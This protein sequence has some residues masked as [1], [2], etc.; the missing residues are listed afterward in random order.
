L[1]LLNGGHGDDLGFVRSMP[2]QA[3]HDS[4]FAR[5]TL[6]A[7]I[8]LRQSFASGEARIK[9]RIMNWLHKDYYQ[10]AFIEKKILQSRNV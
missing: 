2:R 7:K 1:A 10:K 4:G 8:C 5:V 9:A 6:R 3:N